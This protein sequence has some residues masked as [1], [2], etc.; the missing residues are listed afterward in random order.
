MRYDKLTGK[1][2]KDVKTYGLDKVKSGKHVLLFD[3][4]RIESI[5]LDEEYKQLIKETVIR[6]YSIVNDFTYICIG[7]KFDRVVGGVYVKNAHVYNKEGKR[8]YTIIDVSAINL[9]I[10]KRN[11]VY[12]EYETVEVIK[13]KYYQDNSS[14]DIDLVD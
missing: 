12:E 14:Y 5:A 13:E 9:S 1:I 11:N 10:L 8:L 2:S 7:D 3:F 6:D 4:S